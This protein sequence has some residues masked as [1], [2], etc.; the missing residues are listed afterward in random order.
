MSGFEVTF[1][2]QND[3]EG[4]PDETHMFGSTGLMDYTEPFII[5]T[6]TD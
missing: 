2:A 5:K 6:Y 1:S 4:Y 3:I